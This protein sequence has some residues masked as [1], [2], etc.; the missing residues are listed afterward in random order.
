M[1]MEV[2]HLGLLVVLL[3]G[4]TVSG[5]G[6]ISSEKLQPKQT[7]FMVEEKLK[8]LN[9]PSLKT[10]QTDYG[11]VIDCVDIYKQPAFDNPSLANHTIQMK[12][13]SYPITKSENRTLIRN[14]LLNSTSVENYGRKN[15]YIAHSN[16]TISQEANK[17]YKFNF[18]DSNGTS[19]NLNGTANNLYVNRS[20]AFLMTTG[21]S[22]IGAKGEI[23]VWNPYIEKPNEY[24][25]GQIW[26]VSGPRDGFES[27]EAGWMVNPTLYGDTQTRFFIYWTVDGSQK[28][29]CFDL[30]CTG[31][32]Q[33]NHDVALGSPIEPVSSEFDNQYEIAVFI[34]LDV[35][36]SNWWL[37]LNHKEVGYWPGELFVLLRNSAKVVQF[38]GEVYSETIGKEGVRHTSTEMGSGAEAR[39]KSGAAYIHHIR[40]IDYSLTE[41]YP[42]WVIDYM[43]E[44]YC[45]SAYNYVQYIKEPEFFFGGHGSHWNPY[46]Q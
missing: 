20:T 39:D 23:S 38:G 37:M 3:L 18:L 7:D 19:N 41:K 34:F 28:T 14:Q 46:C 45:Y 8:L 5:Y 40:I 24:S 35:N 11:D 21:Y 43:D 31:F 44:P 17:T 36:T 6:A 33:T 29:G 10:I 12:P 16:R 15:P 4:F 13:S 32:V 2:S 26:L 30:T 42:E 22:Y 27:V 9:K 25:T 1:K